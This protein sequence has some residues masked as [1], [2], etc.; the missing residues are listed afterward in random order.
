MKKYLPFLTAAVF[1]ISCSGPDTSKTTG[2]STIAAAPASITAN[3]VLDTLHIGNKT[4][5]VYALDQSPF[6]KEPDPV[7][8]TD[9]IE[10][11][12]LQKD[13]ALV[14]RRNDSLIFQLTNGQSTVLQ[15]SKPDAEENYVKYT[16]EGFLGE[17]KHFGMFAGYYEASDYVLVNQ[18]TGET[19]HTWGTPVISPDKKHILCPSKDLV[20]GFISNGFQLFT[21]DNGKVSLAGELEL[22]KWAP[23]QVKWLDNT[24]LVAEYVS[25]DKNMDEITRPVKIVMQ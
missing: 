7:D 19:I 15:N 14:T 3:Q 22:D 20:A 13:T 11:I 2:D 25:L 8:N 10:A 21:Y 24:T 1:F 9:S 5:F 17:I 4:F 12:A 23:G 18:S 6:G 16:Y